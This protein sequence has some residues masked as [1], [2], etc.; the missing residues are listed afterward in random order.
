MAKQRQV[1]R[2]MV[3]FQQLQEV[4]S[5][6]L[7]KVN[8]NEQRQRKRGISSKLL[9]LLT[10]LSA[11]SIFLVIVRHARVLPKEDVSLAIV[12]PSLV[13]S[14]Q[15]IFSNS[16]EAQRFRHAQILSWK[17]RFQE[18][19]QPVREAERK[20][21][22]L[23]MRLS[24]NGSDPVHTTSNTSCLSS[25]RIVP[26]NNRSI[27]ITINSPIET[28][29]T[30]ALSN[31]DSLIRLHEMGIPVCWL[32]PSIRNRITAWSTIAKAFG[33][34]PRV[35][36]LD[37]CASFQ[38]A[39][40]DLQG[41]WLAVAGLFNSGT[42][43]LYT[44]MRDHCNMRPATNTTSQQPQAPYSDGI[45]WQV[46]WGKHNPAHDR[47]NFT[48]PHGA[49]ISTSQQLPIVMVRHPYA[50][51]E[52]MCHESY[53]AKFLTPIGKHCPDVLT[54]IPN[55][56][57]GISV[58][59]PFGS[60]VEY[61]D[62]VAHLYQKWYREYLYYNATTTPAF[63]RLIVRLEDLIYR[64]QATLQQVCECAGGSF[65]WSAHYNTTLSL[66]TN[67]KR[68]TLGHDNFRS[69]GFFDAWMDKDPK[70]KLVSSASKEYT[71][72]VIDADM[73]KLFHYQL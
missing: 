49:G 56:R 29:P 39:N 48:T 46:S 62:S 71:Q 59:V 67:V 60:G 20:M 66:L 40:P 21:L 30:I 47:Q 27:H 13:L 57:R 33:D 8:Y 45:A 3:A 69:G 37:Q 17:Q 54:H 19:A 4:Q 2:N 25:H 1:Y 36:G 41:R 15:N 53:D 61:Y 5:V 44:S 64:R 38:Q 14:E 72:E 73:M 12:P 34:K 26:T 70:L 55:T 42:N 65:H 24:L 68:T 35:I 50:W 28:V 43:L 32:D 7:H 51:L 16:N 6:H 58:K 23:L 11:A 18:D 22:S 63:P 52:S 31:D 10:A 9:A